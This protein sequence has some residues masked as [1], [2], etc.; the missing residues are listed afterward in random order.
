MFLPKQKLIQTKTDI[1]VLAVGGI[2]IDWLLKMQKLPSFDEKLIADYLGQFPGG[3]VGNFACIASQLGLN[4]A[5]MCTIGDD[6]GGNLILKDFQNYNVD[7]SYVIVDPNITTPFVIVIVDPTGEKA[8]IIPKFHQNRAFLIQ[9]EAIKRSK[10]VY[11]MASDYAHLKEVAVIAHN[12]GTKLMVDIEPSEILLDGKIYE[13]LPYCDIASF[14]EQGFECTLGK[15]FS[16]DALV[17]LLDYGPEVVLVTRGNK[18]VVAADHNE[19]VQVPAY[20]V[21]VNDTTGAGDTFNAAFLFGTFC[22]YNLKKRVE[23][24]TAAAGI[25]IQSV[26]TR[27]NLPTVE[28]IENFIKEQ[29]N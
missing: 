19:I 20:D 7:V 21:P 29:N 1:D 12:S 25:L 16:M 11:M 4:V 3:P 9:P 15:P 2:D 27:T 8:V 14:N 17:E 18:G 13:L 23:Y 6:Q 10:F 28:I 24:G 26:G 22:G 5:S